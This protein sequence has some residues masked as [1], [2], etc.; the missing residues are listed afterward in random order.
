MSLSNSQPTT[1]ARAKGE[2]GLFYS[3][4]RGLWIGRIQLPPGPD[5]KPRRK[6]VTAKT[7]AALQKKL[8]DLRRQLEKQGDLHTAS[9]KVD[10]FLDYWMREIVTPTR[11]PKT[12]TTYR[13]N[14]KWV[15]Q[16]IGRMRLPD[17]KPEHVRRVFTLMRE[18]DP[19]KSSTYQRNVHS[20][21][22]AAFMDAEREGRI[23]R[24][25]VDL[26]PAP[27]KAVT[28]LHALTAREAI[29]LLEVFSQSSE[30]ALW[31]TFILTGARRGEV[32]GLQWDRVTDVLDLSWQLQ[33]ITDG[34]QLPD[35]FEYQHLTDGLYLTRPKTRAGWRIVPLVDPLASI[36]ERYRDQSVTSP[37]GLVF[38]RP[39]G[40]P[41]DPDFVTKQWIKIRELAGISRNVRVHDL[42]H[43]TVDLLYAAGV[44]ETAITAIIG[45]SSRAMSR[46]Y[47]S[48]SDIA[49]LR[50][51][52]LQ[53]SASLAS[54][55]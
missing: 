40:V 9:F 37:Y 53:L 33:R 3:E 42:R 18:A 30:G 41:F 51:G 24:N 21:M 15:S 44:E 10:D 25:P 34:Q 48:R 6:Q 27:K 31:A 39:N 38:A 55:I 26:V 2:G 12:A 7:Q 5:G 19:P 36:L 1:M 11:R 50:K 29:D 23:S 16:A 47:K 46:A 8:S 22:A 52:M 54:D 32:L 43:T 13:S 14:L 45:H 4:A 35:G 49:A 20:V 28:D 17:V